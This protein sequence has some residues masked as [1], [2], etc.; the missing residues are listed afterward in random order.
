MIR[1]RLFKLERE[2]EQRVHEAR[3]REIDRG[4]PGSARRA[5]EAMDAPM[6]EVAAIRKMRQRFGDPKMEVDHQSNLLRQTRRNP[7]LPREV[8]AYR[9]G[10]AKAKLSRLAADYRATETEAEERFFG[11]T[12]QASPPK[13]DPPVSAPAVGNTRPAEEEALNSLSDRTGTANRLGIPQMEPYLGSLVP[14][15][16]SH[17]DNSER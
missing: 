4:G 8:R 6:L 2:A 11:G 12:A 14:E 13:F 9:I 7:D 3:D 17:A 5:S 15:T 1:D 16:G 10:E